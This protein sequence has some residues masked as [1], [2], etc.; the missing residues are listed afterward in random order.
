MT[1]K[2]ATNDITKGWILDAES[3]WS[4]DLVQLYCVQDAD[5]QKVRLSMKG[6][7]TH[8]KLEILH[9]WFEAKWKIGSDQATAAANERVQCQVDNYLG[10]LRRGG[11]L[12]PNNM[13]RK[14]I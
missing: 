11:Q 8:K 2:A 9:G 4:P 5:W 6:V 12:D 10:A 14:Y 3:G 13:I 1:I 7:P